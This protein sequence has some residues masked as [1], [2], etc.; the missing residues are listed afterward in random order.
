MVESD[1]DGCQHNLQHQI[2]HV[3]EDERLL[4]LPV[5]VGQIGSLE[6]RCPKR[7]GHRGTQDALDDVAPLEGRIRIAAEGWQGAA[8]VSTAVPISTLIATSS[9]S[10]SAGWGTTFSVAILGRD[11]CGCPVRRRF[12]RVAL[13][14]GW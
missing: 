9:S 10:S 7:V 1:P 11:W 5:G 8:T 3:D 12:L 6:G 4:P 13:R 14:W 2:H